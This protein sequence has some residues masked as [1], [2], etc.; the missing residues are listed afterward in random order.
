MAGD[1]IC[2]WGGI[3]A[4]VMRCMTR[5]ECFW[6]IS[7]LDWCIGQGVLETSCILVVHKRYK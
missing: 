3:P 4:A 1:G 2:R 5:T 7:W 6:D